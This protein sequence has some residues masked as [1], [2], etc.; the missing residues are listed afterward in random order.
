MQICQ[1]DIKDYR[2]FIGFSIFTT[3]L[4]IIVGCTNKSEFLCENLECNPIN[5]TQFNNR[6]IKI[7]FCSS[8][9]IDNAGNYLTSKEMDLIKEYNKKRMKTGATFENFIILQS[10]CDKAAFF[11]E[12]M[13]WIFWKNNLKNTPLEDFFCEFLA[14]YQNYTEWDITSY[15][16]THNMNYYEFKSEFLSILSRKI[17]LNDYY[18]FHTHLLDN[19]YPI[20]VYQAISNLNNNSENYILEYIQCTQMKKIIPTGVFLQKLSDII[21]KM[22]YALSELDIINYN[23]EIEL[24]M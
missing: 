3:A 5:R 6:G 2:D 10:G 14:L 15:F 19:Y 13:H 18:R 24:V 12:L 4:P 17:I 16:L 11:H 23:K 1:I 21:M 22:N 20:F 7:Y 8:S 9:N